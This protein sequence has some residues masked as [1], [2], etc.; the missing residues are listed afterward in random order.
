MHPSADELMN[1]SQEVLHDL[2]FVRGLI[3][4]KALA[5]RLHKAPGF[6]DDICRRD[7][8]DFVAVFNECLRF[9]EALAQTNPAWMLAIAG[10]IFALVTEGTRWSA[11]WSGPLPEKDMQYTRLCEQAGLLCEDLGGA[12]KAMA[13]IESDG[14]YTESDDAAIAEFQTKS[15]LLVGRLRVLLVEVTRRRAAA[16]EPP[17]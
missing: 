8:V 1:R 4:A 5:Y 6:I 13:A 7:R 3:P 16:K 11:D 9:G 15:Q 17:S 12:L 10:P 2:C 14:R